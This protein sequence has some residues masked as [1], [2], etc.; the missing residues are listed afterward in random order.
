MLENHL[1]LCRLLIHDILEKEVRS[2]CGDRY[3]HHKPHDGRYSSWGY[4]PSSVQIDPQGLLIEVP[5]I[6]DNETG[7][8]LSLE[9]AERL[10]GIIVNEE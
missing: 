8:M 9:T 3:H 2:L 5:R 10:S 1:D 7:K 4:N 6:R